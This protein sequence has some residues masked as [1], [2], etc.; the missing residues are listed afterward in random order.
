MMINY[1]IWMKVSVSSQKDRLIRGIVGS[2][3]AARGG[4]N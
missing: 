2:T 4:V 3:Q 1:I